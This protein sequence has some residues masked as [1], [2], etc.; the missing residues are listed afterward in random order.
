M[1]YKELD[2]KADASKISLKIY[3]HNIMKKM[4]KYLTFRRKKK[5]DITDNKVD[6]IIYGV[7]DNRIIEEAMDVKKVTDDF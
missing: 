3:L 1:V 4:G 7:E 5:F 2:R 6:D